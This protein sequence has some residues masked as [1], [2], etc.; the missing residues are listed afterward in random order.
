MKTIFGCLLWIVMILSARAQSPFDNTPTF[1]QYLIGIHQKSLL[2]QSSIET[3]ILP[4]GTLV[5]YQD[6]PKA[7]GEMIRIII[8]IVLPRG[9]KT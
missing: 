5:R 4:D 8:D 7:N 3:F 6:M 9:I 1:K 2:K